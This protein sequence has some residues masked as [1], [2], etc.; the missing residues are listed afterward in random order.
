MW[1]GV[2]GGRVAWRGPH[3]PPHALTPL[4][5]QEDG[6]APGRGGGKWDTKTVFVCYFPHTPPPVARAKSILGGWLVDCQINTDLHAQTVWP[7]V[8]D[9]APK[10]V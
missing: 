10:R 7:R 6:N 4:F 8:V 5:S 9:L 2:G 3:S 1:D